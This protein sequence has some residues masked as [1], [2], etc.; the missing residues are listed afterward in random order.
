MV[1]NLQTSGTAPSK[2]INNAETLKLDQNFGVKNRLSFTFTRNASYSNSAYD[3]DTSNWSNWGPRLP[4][5]LDRQ[6]LPSRL[7]VLRGRFPHERHPPH[8]SY[9]D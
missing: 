6:D 4:F 5:P 9:L 3:K 1:S 8:H 2:A 7:D